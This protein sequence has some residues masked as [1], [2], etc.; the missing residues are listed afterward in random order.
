MAYKASVLSTG[1]VISVPSHTLC[2]GWEGGLPLCLVL[3]GSLYT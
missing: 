2:C 1:N 3:E